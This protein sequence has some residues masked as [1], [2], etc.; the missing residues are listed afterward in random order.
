M[1]RSEAALDWLRDAHE[2]STACRCCGFP[3]RTDD[4]DEI[5]EA[6]ARLRAGA[7]DVVVLGTGGSSL[8]GQTLAQLAGVGVR[9]VEAFRAGPRLHFMDN[10]DPGTYGALLEKLPLA[11]TR[12]VA[13]SKSGGTGETLMQTAAAL[14]AVKAAGLDGA[15]RRTVRRHQRSREARQ[16]AMACAICSGRRSRCWSTIRASAGAIRC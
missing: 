7:T 3:A 10:L 11:T 14:S 9:G 15:H 2:T 6:A 16:A 13:I 1:T 4:L 12:F 8:G 5:S